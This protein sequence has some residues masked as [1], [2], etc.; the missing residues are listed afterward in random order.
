MLG[1]KLV[2]QDTAS[3]AQFPCCFS[4]I[5]GYMWHILRLFFLFI[6]DTVMTLDRFDRAI[7][8]AL[9]ND[10]R[11]S[12]V[13]LAGMVNLSESACLRRVR[14]LE[15]EGF[16]DRYVALLSQKAVGLSG[17]IFVHIAL[18]REEQSELAAFEAA[19]RDIPEIMECYLM[20]G[21]FDYLLRVVVSDMADF[22]RLHN[23]GLTR[24]PGVSRVNSSVAIRTVT[25]T[26]ELP[27][28]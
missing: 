6:A 10:G 7:L 2:A 20:T 27:L 28:G 11:I 18:R 22:E 19:V 9:Q 17:T 8:G 13:Q 21:E 12:N 16:I 4:A 5:P 14:T 23:E 24:L 26:T 3:S 1:A 25:K 15:Q